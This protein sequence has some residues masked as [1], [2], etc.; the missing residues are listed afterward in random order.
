VKSDHLTSFVLL[1]VDVPSPLRQQAGM[2]HHRE[3]GSLDSR[4][5]VVR[6]VPLWP[7]SERN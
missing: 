5:E 6:K 4:L 1:S 2:R 7:K 3:A